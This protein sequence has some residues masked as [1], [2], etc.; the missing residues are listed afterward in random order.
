MVRHAFLLCLALMCVVVAPP[1][2]AD[3]QVTL[4]QAL[5]IARRRSPALRAAAANAESERAQMDIQKAN[6]YP[7]LT[8]QVGG[9]AAA[10]RATNPL[11][12]SGANLFLYV[13]YQ[14]AGQGSLNA[15]WTLYDFGKTAGAVANA[16][17]QLDGAVATVGLTDLTL[18]TTVANA[19]I[20][21][22]FSEK[23]W[24]VTKQT[25]ENRE[26]LVI[27]A[28]G[29]IKAGLQPPLEE[30][31]ASA[32]AEAARRDVVGAEAAV[33][34]ARAVLAVILGFNPQSSLRVFEPKLGRLSFDVATAMRESAHL[35][36]VAVADAAVA[37]YQGSIDAARAQ[38][39]PT[40]AFQGT[41]SYTYSKYDT[42]DSVLSTGS[43]TGLVTLT[44]NIFSA[45][46]APTLRTAE[47]NK[48]N[49]IGTADQAR[50]DARE[51][52]ARSVEAS[53]EAERFLD[54]ARKAADAAA[55]VLAIVQAR[56]VQGLSSP[57]EL[58]DAETSDS[59]ARVARTQ[60][61]F[62]YQ[63]SIIRALVATGRKIVE[64]S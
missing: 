61:E 41:A 64:V 18:L 23:L 55:G 28:K 48:A 26:K 63:L 50:Q 54:H 25:L 4:Q 13:N 6:Y 15:Q 12:P 21:L 31:R 39:L 45:S 37:Q 16:Q 29:L 62:S 34:D 51:E 49:A 43:A 33:V 36:A 47:E 5:E 20:T 2:R 57:L 32:R 46:I 35:P 19:Y 7:Q 8:A 59:V 60:A 30:I 52:A 1:A 24:E 17:G 14:G 42:Y 10:N 56:Y 40:L 58:I 3:T 11:P 38:Y 27:L 22:V 53:V 9:Q 44:E